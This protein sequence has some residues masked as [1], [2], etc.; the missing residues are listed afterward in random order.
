MLIWLAIGRH[1]HAK[2]H[3]VAT[4]NNRDHMPCSLY[5]CLF[6][7]CIHKCFS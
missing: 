3:T 1:E 5:Y 4:S 2:P 6:T 7:P